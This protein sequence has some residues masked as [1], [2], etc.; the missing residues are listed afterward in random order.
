[1]RRPRGKSATGAFGGL[2]FASLHTNG[3]REQDGPPVHEP[4]VG[5]KKIP[6]LP[7]PL[8]PWG[9]L[10]EERENLR[11]EILIGHLQS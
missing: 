5:A 3:D 9:P 6:P 11:S 4:Y 1:M 2:V 8:L 7:G 10:G